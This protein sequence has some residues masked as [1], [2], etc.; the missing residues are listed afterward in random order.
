MC[1]FVSVTGLVGAL[2]AIAL[3]LGGPS[4]AGGLIEGSLASAGFR[5]ESTSVE[6]DTDEPWDVLG[7]RADRITIRA[8]DAT[9]D[10]LQAERLQLVLTDADLSGRSFGQVD[11]R[12]EGVTL[13]AADGTAVHAASVDISG[14]PGE[15]RASIRIDAAEIERL[16]LAEVQRQTGTEIGSTSIREPD[17]VSFTVLVFTVEGRFVVESDGAL[18]LAVALPGNPQVRLIA[19]PSIRFDSVQVTDGQLVL[20][21]ILSLP[22]LDGL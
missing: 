16:A 9:I 22:A 14:P 8:Q 10:Q 7:G 4:I 13:Q 6:V 12:L 2:V 1:A 3:W 11:G 17:I 5:G 21:G 19:D 15:V 20:G 18:G